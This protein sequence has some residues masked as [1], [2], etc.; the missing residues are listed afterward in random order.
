MILKSIHYSSGQYETQ[1]WKYENSTKY[2][3][4]LD[5]NTLI[6]A[7]CFVHYRDKHKNEYYGHVI[8]LSTSFGCPMKCKYCASSLISRN[9]ILSKDELLE[10]FDII[11]NNEISGFPGKVNLAVSFLGIGDLFFTLSNVLACMNQIH[12]KFPDILFNLSSCYW[13][14][15]MIDAVKQSKCYQ[16]INTLQ[17]TYVSTSTDIVKS[18]IPGFK[19]MEYSFGSMLQ[20]MCEAFDNK[21]PLINYV[22]IKDINSSEASFSDFVACI[23]PFKHSISVRIS[24]MNPTLASDMNKLSSPSKQS[25]KKLL[26]ILSANGINSYLFYSC[27]NDNM[28]CGQLIT[29]NCENYRN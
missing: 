1:H 22:M 8:E 19:N 18:I 21:V 27:Q 7:G 3:F 14:H 5:D 12:D 10:I 23:E 13:T 24:S 15:Q 20:I 9:R 25:M 17:L 4:A 6:E 29:E 26:E 11:Y 28:N 2:V 16:S